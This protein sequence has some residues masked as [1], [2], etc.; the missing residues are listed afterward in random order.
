MSHLIREMKIL[1]D[2]LR[3]PSI[4][5]RR[6]V[7]PSRP[8]SFTPLSNSLQLRCEG[9]RNPMALTLP[10]ID[11][12]LTL[13][14]V[15]LKGN[16]GSESCRMS[17]RATC[18]RIKA[19][20]TLMMTPARV[21]FLSTALFPSVRLYTSRKRGSLRVNLP[22]RSPT[23]MPPSSVTSTLHMSQIRSPS[24]KTVWPSSSHMLPPKRRLGISLR[25]IR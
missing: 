6:A 9:S 23:S 4:Y 5:N 16:I 13:S 12:R 20:V 19:G 22:L 11:L 10:K 25:P 14:W 1:P 7:D 8:P 21:P 3:T 18:C 24:Y 15:P 17:T 2:I